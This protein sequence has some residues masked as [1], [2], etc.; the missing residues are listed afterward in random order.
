M[1]AYT[2]GQTKWFIDEQN[3]TTLASNANTGLDATHPLLT[4]GERVRRMGRNF[5]WSASRY[6]I[7]CLSDVALM[8]L[9]GTRR[10]GSQIWVHGSGTAYQ[11]RTILSSGNTMSQCAVA[12]PSTRTRPSLRGGSAGSFLTTLANRNRRLRLTSGARAGA[13]AFA[14]SISGSD[15]NVSQWTSLSTWNPL[16]FHIPDICDP[17]GT[18]TYVVESLGSIGACYSALTS[19]DATSSDST[20]VTFDSIN[21]G[22]FGCVDSTA[23]PVFVGCTGVSPIS[24]DE[25]FFIQA[26]VGMFGCFTIASLIST[27]INVNVFSC[28]NIGAWAGGP[29]T[30]IVFGY[31]TITEGTPM[32]QSVSL[33]GIFEVV[34]AAVFNS[35]TD[36]ARVGDGALLS[37]QPVSAGSGPTVVVE[38][39]LW[40]SGSAGAGVNVQPGGRMSYKAGLLP[41]VTGA[42]D[43]L[44]GDIK[45]SW[46]DG[47][48]RDDGANA[49]VY[50]V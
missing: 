36:G 16:T 17:A 44:V 37:V 23:F 14:Q 41:N 33:G 42:R 32:I 12:V 1:S 46:S 38:P 11:G 49:Q 43:R 45:G 29:A 2:S 48:V 28:H 26:S 34:G 24:P 50:A 30:S 15:I 27:D 19:T 22:K 6:D 4:D 39:A 7:W 5:D 35:T 31:N 18:E 10:N 20:G 9:Y 25:N 40:G 3:V 13:T 8:E 47:P 21:F